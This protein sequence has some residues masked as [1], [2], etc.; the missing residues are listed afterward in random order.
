MKSALALFAT[1]KSDDV[2]A[3]QY[4]MGAL[5]VQFQE[6]LIGRLQEHVGEVLPQRQGRRIAQ[7]TL[8][9]YGFSRDEITREY[10]LVAEF[11]SEGRDGF[12]HFVDNRGR[13]GPREVARR[14]GGKGRALR[15]VEGSTAQDDG[16]SL[17]QLRRLVEQT[18]ELHPVSGEVPELVTHP[19]R[20]GR[21]VTLTN[22]LTSVDHVVAHGGLL[23]VGA[24]VGERP[25]RGLN[26]L[27]CLGPISVYCEIGHDGPHGITRRGV[28]RGNRQWS[29]NV[30]AKRGLYSNDLPR[31][32]YLRRRLWHG[33]RLKV[34]G[35]RLRD[36]WAAHDVDRYGTISAPPS[37]SNQENHCSEKTG[38][39]GAE[40]IQHVDEGCAGGC[41]HFL[42]RRQRYGQFLRERQSD[43]RRTSDIQAHR[44]ESREAV[45]RHTSRVS[46]RDDDRAA[47]IRDRHREV[48]GRVDEAVVSRGIEVVRLVD[49]I[50]PR[51]GVATARSRDVAQGR[52]GQWRH[53]RKEVAPKWVS[54]I[55]LNGARTHPQRQVDF[56][57]WCVQAPFQGACGVQDRP[58]KEQDAGQGGPVGG[59]GNGNPVTLP[60]GINRALL[61]VTG[62]C[63]RR[64]R[65]RHDKTEPE[66]ECCAVQS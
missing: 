58:R 23:D 17:W 36:W 56:A 26:L 20:R 1:S 60:E 64:P 52:S 47:T 61:Q 7:Q 65:K 6:T 18:L 28:D 24:G 59:V 37:A 44:R 10:K 13:K 48:V 27:E 53:P 55:A 39:D 51:R 62:T 42:W 30:D 40:N 11:V 32:S 43:A 34:T 31:R 66:R 46:R 35:R 12:D 5:P 21:Q 14:F 41:H 22:R 15:K 54:V 3:S 9:K 49:W 16:I 63:W 19:P 2:I 25:D 57:L 33:R 4:A 45:V 8:A 50:N 29:E 38:Q